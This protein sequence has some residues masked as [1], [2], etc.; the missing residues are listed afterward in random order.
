M[1]TS[2]KPITGYATTFEPDKP[3]V[4]R[5]TMTCG[6]CQRAVFVKPGTACTTYLIFDRVNWRWQE[7]PGAFCRVCMRPVCLSPRC[8]SSCRVW[9]E[10]LERSEARDRLRRQVGV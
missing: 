3:I 4:E 5:D 9:E 6:H 8:L 1:S 10:R 7:E 2:G